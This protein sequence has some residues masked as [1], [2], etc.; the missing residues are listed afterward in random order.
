MLYKSV[1]SAGEAVYH[2]EEVESNPAQSTSHDYHTV[3][4]DSA[5][6]ENEPQQ[7]EVPVPQQHNVH[8]SNE[9]GRRKTVLRDFAY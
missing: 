3:E 8:K 5:Y 9:V 6:E 1:S 7:Y 2:Y 4:P